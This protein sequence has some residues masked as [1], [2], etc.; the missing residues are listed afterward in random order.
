MFIIF[1]KIFDKILSL[2]YNNKNF[3]SFLIYFITLFWVIFLIY[4][5]LTFGSIESYIIMYVIF[6]TITSIIDR[7]GYFLEIEFTHVF[8]YLLIIIYETYFIA[9][10]LFNEP[11]L[12]QEKELLSLFIIVFVFLRGIW[13]QTLESRKYELKKQI[14]EN[15]GKDD[16]D[17]FP[18]AS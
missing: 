10:D 16:R 5:D 17:S 9:Y 4:Q 6:Y 2:F 15:G 3:Y 7:T 18:P 1:N 11:R 13:V 14:I 12:P 8:S